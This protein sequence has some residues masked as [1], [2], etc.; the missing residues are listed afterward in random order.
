MESKV[1][2]NEKINNLLED[3]QNQGNT[4]DG[5]STIA[6]LDI[7]VEELTRGI[8]ERI[9]ELFRPEADISFDFGQSRDGAS[10]IS[11]IIDSGEEKSIS[12]ETKKEPT[13]SELLEQIMVNY[14]SLD[15]EFSQENLEAMKASILAVEAK[16]SPTEET[17]HLFEIL[18]KL[19][20]WFLSYEQTVSMISLT[21]FKETLQFLNKILQKDQKVDE[22]DRE[23]VEQ[24]EKRFNILRTQYEVKEPDLEPPSPKAK[25]AELVETPDVT[26]PKAPSISSIEDVEK[27]IRNLKMD[28]ERANLRLRKVISILDAR[29]KLKPVADRLM[30]IVNHYEGYLDRMGSIETFLAFY[31]KEPHRAI[32]TIEK[33]LVTPLEITEKVSS[34]YAPEEVVSEAIEPTPKESGS[35]LESLVVQEVYLFLSQGKYFAIPF[36]QL[37][38]YDNISSEKAHTLSSKGYGTLKD[39]KPFFK[40]IKHGVH[41]FWRN[42]SSRELKK[43]VF[44]Y[45]DI[46]KKLNLPQ[47]KGEY[48]GMVIFASNGI[49]NVVF[50]VDSIISDAPFS[51]INLRPS[52]SP[53]ALGIA[54]LNK[55]RNIEIINIEALV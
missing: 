46:K 23:I 31:S 47:I 53:K 30:K 13:L 26:K 29:P 18:K 24:L 17:R 20:N 34:Q 22:K 4:S 50:I 1:E 48:G 3:E 35:P 7:S 42:K 32:S 16:I 52:D 33:E 51:I 25:V 21:L 38:K 41:G 9:D 36:D 19:L 44:E 14:L 2:E 8:E 10:I 43:M 28:L 5:S 15:W 54:D 40:S 6:E 45:V 39:I 27:E 55:Y 11:E 12:L 37:I 49:K